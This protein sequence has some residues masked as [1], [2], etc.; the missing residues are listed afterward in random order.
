MIDYGKGQKL[1]PIGGISNAISKHRELNYKNR[2]L[3]FKKRQFEYKKIRDEKE[4]QFKRDR[5]NSTNN[6]FDRKLKEAQAKRETDSKYRN[7]KMHNDNINLDKKLEE[8]KKKRKSN[9]KVSRQNFVA[10]VGH[11]IVE[12]HKSNNNLEREKIRKGIQTNNHKFDYHK[13][14]ESFLNKYGK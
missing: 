4:S 1:N 5:L 11:D 13:Q 9:E 8:S 2:E 10:N 3:D 14:V 7:E 6:N 12:L